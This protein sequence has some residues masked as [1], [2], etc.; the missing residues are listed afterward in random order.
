[1]N[2]QPINDEIRVSGV[3][4]IVVLFL[5]WFGIVYLMPFAK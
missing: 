2:K 4:F 5:C 3:V 1:M